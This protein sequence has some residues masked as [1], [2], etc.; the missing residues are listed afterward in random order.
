[1][2]Q[3]QEPVYLYNPILQGSTTSLALD[4]VLLRKSVKVFSLYLY[5]ILLDSEYEYMKNRK[6]A[7]NILSECGSK[8]STQHPPLTRKNSRACGMHGG[9]IRDDA[10]SQPQA[11]S[12]LNDLTNKMMEILT[13]AHA[14]CLPILQL[15]Q[16]A[17]SWI[18]SIMLCGPR[19][20]I[21]Q[22]LAKTSWNISMYT[23][24]GLQKLIHLFGDSELRMSLSKDGWSTLWIRSWLQT[25]FASP[26]PNS[27]GILLLQFI[28]IGPIHFKFMIS[29][30]CNLHE[31]SRWIYWKLLQRPSR[32]MSRWYPEL[33]LILQEDTSYIFLDG[34]D[35]RL[36]KIQNDVL[37]LKTF[38]T[39]EKA[40]AHV[41]REDVQQTVMTSVVD[42]SLGVDMASKVIKT[43]QS[44]M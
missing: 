29:G 2:E 5:F 7:V 30:V 11:K 1:M 3:L 27:Y 26:L 31:T 15:L 8:N 37:Q 36:E 12:I 39:I 41:Q 38:P 43:C 10:A 19:L 22:S 16:L 28:L 4:N 44:N 13:R 14:H 25:S 21:C 20:S 34:F 6:F 33:N 18:A 23:L 35:D 32:G 24:P 42:F 9:L 40:Y 17:L